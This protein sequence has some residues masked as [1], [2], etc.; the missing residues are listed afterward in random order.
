MEIETQ[1]TIARNLGYLQGP[2]TDG[3]LRLSSEVGRM[4]NGLVQSIR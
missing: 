4:L 3:L 1:I 2:E